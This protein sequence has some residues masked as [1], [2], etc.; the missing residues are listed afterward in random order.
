LLAL[1]LLATAAF[2]GPKGT[3]PRSEARVYPLHG[4][5]G[6]IGVGAKLLTREEAR[7]TFVSDVNRCCLVFEIAVYPEPGKSVDVSLDSFALR[8][9]SGDT[10][11]K[12]STAKVVAASIQKGA[13][14]DRDITISPTT[15]VG[16]SSGDVYDPATGTRRRGG[17]YTQSGVDVAIGSPGAGPGASDKDRSVMETELSDKGLPEGTTPKAVAGYVYFPV[18]PK[19]KG[20]YQLEYIS[21]DTKIALPV[22]VQ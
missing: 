2:A 10:A 13:E 22:H 4:E 21:S 7:K 5:S 17:V 16:Y 20:D 6:D 9:K 15:G 3:V 12:P 8:R 18:S 11:V 14:G 1:L 19:K